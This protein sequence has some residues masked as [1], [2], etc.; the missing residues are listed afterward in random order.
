LKQMD[1]KLLKGTLSQVD[2]EKAETIEEAKAEASDQIERDWK[3]RQQIQ[4][5]DALVKAKE[6]IDH[7]YGAVLISTSKPLPTVAELKTKAEGM[8]ITRLKQEVDELEAE[9]AGYETYEEKIRARIKEVA[10]DL[11]SQ[12]VF[13]SDTTLSE[14]ENYLIE[15]GAPH[16]AT[17]P[18]WFHDGVSRDL[19]AVKKA[20]PFLRENLTVFKDALQRKE[21]EDSEKQQVAE[22]TKKRKGLKRILKAVELNSPLRRE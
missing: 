14:I 21:Q 4:R 1:E 18:G 7:F 3:R 11:K 10:Q 2:I 6:I 16:G 22:F 5:G 17:M 13:T 19:E 12:H 8:S 20:I 9:L 15:Q